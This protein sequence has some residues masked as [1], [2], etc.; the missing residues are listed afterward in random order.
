MQQDKW[1]AVAIHPTGTAPPPAARAP[2]D[3]RA[4]KVP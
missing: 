3:K 1:F 4:L 2:V